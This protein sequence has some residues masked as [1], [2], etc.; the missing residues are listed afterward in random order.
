MQH[1]KSREKSATIAIEADAET[2]VENAKA[3][4]ADPHLIV[5]T[6]QSEDPT[7]EPQSPKRALHHHQNDA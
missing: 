7:L 6:Q 2:A 3:A 1:E 4:I 5:K